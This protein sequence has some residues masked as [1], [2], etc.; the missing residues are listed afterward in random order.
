MGRAISALG[1]NLPVASQHTRKLTVTGAATKPRTRRGNAKRR[2]RRATLCLDRAPPPARV[3]TLLSQGV[4]AQ[5][6]I[7][8]GQVLQEILAEMNEGDHDLLVVGGHMRGTW[9]NVPERDLASELV[10][11]ADRPVLVVKAPRER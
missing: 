9:L 10:R 11:E 5:A 6:K 4:A 2:T 3:E 7:R 1:R 8:R